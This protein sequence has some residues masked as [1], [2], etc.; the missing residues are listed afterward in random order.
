M[1]IDASVTWGAGEILVLSIG[2]M[3]IRSWVAVSFG[4]TEIN[5]V[6]L[7]TTFS[8]THQEVIRF[9]ISVDET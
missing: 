8:N 1:C 7:I 2:Y 9:D 4:Q 6:D 5:H 3:Y